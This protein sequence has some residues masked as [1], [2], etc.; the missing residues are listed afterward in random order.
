MWRQDRALEVIDTS[1]RGVK[2]LKP[3]RFEDDRGY[4]S[5]TWNHQ[6]LTNLGIYIDFVQDNQSYS[7]EKGT[8]RGMHFQVPP[9]A[10]DKLVRV[11]VGRIW[12][13]AVDIR[14]DSVTYGCWTGCELSASNGCQLLI[15]K[16]FMHGFV[17]LEDNTEV[18]YKCSDYYSPEA[19]GSVRFDDPEIGIDWKVEVS[20]AIVSSK[21][22]AAPLLMSLDSPFRLEDE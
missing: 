7:R 2:I 13:V 18:V 14:K 12:D 11:V 1:L 4:F 9:H 3:R 17:T 16:G 20:E 10:Q 19:E 22:A 8:V 5:E 6:S 21:D 15:T